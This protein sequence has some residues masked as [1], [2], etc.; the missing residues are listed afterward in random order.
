MEAR[1]AIQPEWH[2]D[3]LALLHAGHR[4][5][6]ELFLL[7]R[8]AENAYL[9]AQVA[10]GALDRDDIAG[11]LIGHWSAGQLAGVCIL[12][13]NLVISEP[14]SHT[15]IEGFAEYAR[16]LGVPFWVAVGPD[17]TIQHFL[18]SYGR[19][20]RQIR[21]ERGNQVLYG[22]TREA[23][24][25][26]GGW[27]GLRQAELEDVETLVALDR[28]MVS[29]EIGFDPFTTVIGAYRQGWIRRVRERR[30]WVIGP[31]GGSLTFKIDQSAVSRDAVQL[32]GIYTAPDARRQGIARGG[33]GAMCRLLLESTPLVTLYVHGDNTPA[34]RLYE[35]LG[36]QPLAL[37]RSV[38]FQV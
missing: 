10:R 9:L 22:L 17:A 8:P 23:A 25:A 1:L 20:T 32:A 38:W 4:R 14:A 36:F 37:V 30:A 3:G 7:Q 24:P 11:P 35:G 12:G 16:R 33:V 27:D 2:T 28:R 29:E 5:L 26:P 15:A 31:V 18:E 6:V 21:L 13:S 19:D 34:V